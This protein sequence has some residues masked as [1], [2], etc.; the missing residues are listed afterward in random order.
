MIGMTLLVLLYML[1]WFVAL[2]RHHK[3]SPA[4][5]ALNL[6]L[7]WSIIGWIIALVW[8]YTDNVR[9]RAQA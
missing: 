9:V 8:A 5:A 1:P 7:G 2:G 6:L 4:I 3:N